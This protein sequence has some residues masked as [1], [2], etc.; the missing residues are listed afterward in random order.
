MFYEILG[1]IQV[2]ISFSTPN[3]QQNSPHAKSLIYPELSGNIS[4]IPTDWDDKNVKTLQTFYITIRSE[5]AAKFHFVCSMNYNEE[6]RIFLKDATPLT[7]SFS[8]EDK[9]YHYFIFE[10]VFLWY[11]STRLSINL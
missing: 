5:T 4:F 6:T 1:K 11:T 10:S 9:T 3:P 7:Y 2:F 8:S